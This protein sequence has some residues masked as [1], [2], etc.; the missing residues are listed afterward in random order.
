MEKKRKIIK[1]NNVPP[2]KKKKKFNVLIP[3]ICSCEYI[4]LDG[5]KGF[6]DVI[7]LK[8]LIREDYT[9]IYRWSQSIHKGAL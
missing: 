1:L 2:S 6:A 8:I 3:G 9:E 5:K 7:N 4:S